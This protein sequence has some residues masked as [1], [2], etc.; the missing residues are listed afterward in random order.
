MVGE[1]RLELLHLAILDPKLSVLRSYAGFGT[2]CQAVGVLMRISANVHTV[3]VSDIYERLLTMIC[4]SLSSGLILG[5][6]SGLKALLDR[7]LS[8]DSGLAWAGKRGSYEAST[9]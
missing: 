1:K 7:K 9:V 5:W 2:F 3:R 4:L 8:L 6:K